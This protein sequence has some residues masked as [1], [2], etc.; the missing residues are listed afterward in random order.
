MS[1]WGEGGGVCVCLAA[2]VSSS[3]DMVEGE[4]KG[5]E[6]AVSQDKRVYGMAGCCVRDACA[7]KMA[8]SAGRW[9]CFP[10]F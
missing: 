10:Q 7:V 9:I 3:Q 1:V 6:W 8:P 2:C 4:L 5:N